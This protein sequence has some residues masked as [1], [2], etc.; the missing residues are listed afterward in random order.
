MRTIFDEPAAD[1]F[2]VL[3]YDHRGASQGL[4]E[5]R[6]QIETDAHMAREEK[7]RE[8]QE[9]SKDHEHLMQ[10]GAE[11]KCPYITTVASDGTVVREHQR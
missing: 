7:E 8:R 5:L 3:D 6:N 9:L 10:R 2:A 1:S 4:T 11:S